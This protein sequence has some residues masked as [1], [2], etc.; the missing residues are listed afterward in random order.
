MQQHTAEVWG[1]AWQM[2]DRP[3]PKVFSLVGKPA[4]EVRG[5]SSQVSQVGTGT[6]GRVALNRVGWEPLAAE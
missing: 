4:E 5:M 2:E 3:A 1:P 6:E